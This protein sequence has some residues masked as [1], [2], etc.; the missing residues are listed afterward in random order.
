MHTTSVAI[1]VDE[2]GTATGMC[3]PATTNEN[4]AYGM[5]CDLSLMFNQYLIDPYCAI[6]HY[7][8]S[9]NK[10][11]RGANSLCTKV[12]RKRNFLAKNQ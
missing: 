5:F 10:I 4:K 9:T 3:P 11:H 6:L 1:Y 2:M 7:S 8:A 12:L